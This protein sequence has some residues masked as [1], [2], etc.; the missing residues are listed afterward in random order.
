[1]STTGRVWRFVTGAVSL[2]IGFWMANLIDSGVPERWVPVARYSWVIAMF[3]L[4]F[5]GL[6]ALI[7][8]IHPLFGE[9]EI[10]WFPS[11]TELR[12][13]QGLV[14]VLVVGL[15]IIITAVLVGSLRPDLL[16]RAAI[17]GGGLFIVFLAIARARGFWDNPRIDFWRGI[18]GDQLVR[19][20]Y[21]AIGLAC[22]AL[23]L[24]SKS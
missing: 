12:G 7:Q 21:V 8:V 15:F 10:A 11:R 18:L 5:F 16:G 2:A 23:A 20:F 3:I 6:G 9:G 13:R 19:W 17:A 22:I 24:L 14:A 4:M 1:M